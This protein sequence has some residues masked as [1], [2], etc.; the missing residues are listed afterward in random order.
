MYIIMY[1]KILVKLL[2]IFKMMF[3]IIPTQYR[4]CV[5][6][7]LYLNFDITEVVILWFFPVKFSNKFFLKLLKFFNVLVFN[8]IKKKNVASTLYYGFC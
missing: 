4:T 1:V 6:C 7:S 5:S 3:E 2:D 8:T